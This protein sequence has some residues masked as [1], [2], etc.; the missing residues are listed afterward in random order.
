MGR[1]W[2]GPRIG[3]PRTGLRIEV[4]RQR[5][6]YRS[7]S[8]DRSEPGPDI[9]SGRRL[10]SDCES[11]RKI[12]T[13]FCSLPL[14]GGACAAALKDTDAARGGHPSGP[15]RHADGPTR[16][17][18]ELHQLCALLL[19]FFAMPAWAAPG[20]LVVGHIERGKPEIEG[21]QCDFSDAG[22]IVLRSDWVSRFWMNIDGS[23]VEFRGTRTDE[24][25]EA[26]VVGRRWR[27]SFRVQGISVL[28][29]LKQTATGDDGA[30]FE[31]SIVV[32]RGGFATHLKVAGGCGA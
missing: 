28:L 13:R 30:A 6:R 17:N 9:Q 2:A 20:T 26:D 12:A 29:N 14:V 19:L 1:E 4:R 7:T 8:S 27:E 16:R 21:S 24:A 11:D 22:G 15:R 23:L 31:G 18:P 3:T 25:K 32:K 10:T 5:W